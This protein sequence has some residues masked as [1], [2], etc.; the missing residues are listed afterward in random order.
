MSI[1]FHGSSL[2]GRPG[3]KP[4]GGAM[5]SRDPVVA[6]RVAKGVVYD[7]KW[8]SL[9]HRDD[10]QKILAAIAAKARW[11]LLALPAEA[12]ELLPA[13]G[14]EKRLGACN[15][16]AA[17]ALRFPEPEAPR[18]EVLLALLGNGCA[19][20]QRRWS[21]AALA[22]SAAQEEAGHLKTLT[23][24]GGTVAD[25]VRAMERAR[26]IVAGKTPEPSYYRPNRRS[27]G[28]Y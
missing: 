10:K 7:G 4:Y 13:L 17:A 2:G 5:S 6:A 27:T 23:A 18:T 1:M 15:W 20:C 26:R 24:G 22:A 16:C 19:D 21:T 8:R 11:A 28:R 25:T 9:P 14:W 3:G 12:V